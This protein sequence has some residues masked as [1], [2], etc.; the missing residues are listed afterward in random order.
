MKKFKS[1]QKRDEKMESLLMEKWGYSATTLNED[2]DKELLQELV[3][4]GVTITAGMYYLAAA[5]LAMASYYSYEVYDEDQNLK[6]LERAQTEMKTLSS[7]EEYGDQIDTDELYYHDDTRETSQG[8]LVG[9]TSDEDREELSKGEQPAISTVEKNEPPPLVVTT[10]EDGVEEHAAPPGWRF[11]DADLESDNWNIV[12]DDDDPEIADIPANL[13][14]TAG[15]TS[16]VALESR[17]ATSHARTKDIVKEEV[18]KYFSNRR[19]S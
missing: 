15:S 1:M 4:A 6:A 14:S 8:G 9:Q 7:T 2:G 11:E 19:K 12:P 18:V 5:T 17:A 3:I 13:P 16:G 10:R